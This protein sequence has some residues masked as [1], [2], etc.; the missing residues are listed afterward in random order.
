MFTQSEAITLLVGL[1]LQRSLQAPLFPY[2]MEM[3]EKKLLA[4]L[5]E[6][7]RTLLEKAERIL[8][9]EKFPHDIFHPEPA[10]PLPTTL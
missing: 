3:V 10:Q 2:E 1:T 8:E 9:F 4:A 5:S 6:R 7:L